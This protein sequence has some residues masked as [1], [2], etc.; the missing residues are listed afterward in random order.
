MARI[1]V[2]KLSNKRAEE[3]RNARSLNKKDEQAKAALAKPGVLAFFDSL[4]GEKERRK[5][6][7]R[8]GSK[9]EVAKA[10]LATGGHSGYYTMTGKHGSLYVI[11]DD[12]KIEDHIKLAPKKKLS[13]EAH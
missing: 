11:S 3:I 13:K 10:V 8:P 5:R 7:K 12:D 2:G 1:K 6:A 4:P 9:F